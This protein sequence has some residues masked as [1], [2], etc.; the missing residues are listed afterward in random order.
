MGKENLVGR[1]SFD[2]NNSNDSS[3]NN[4]HGSAK[5]LFQPNELSNLHTWLDASDT[6]S[7]SI[8]EATTSGRVSTWHDKSGNQKDYSTG[9]GSNWNLSTDTTQPYTNARTIN[10]LNVLDF[11]GTEFLR[12]N[13]SLNLQNFSIFMVGEFDNGGTAFSFSNYSQTRAD[14]IS[15]STSNFQGKLTRLS[16]IHI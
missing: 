2:N 10:S 5:R 9:G 12:G 1:W 3:G 15:N 6:S 4:H 11:R 7:S 13:H 8:S 14:F 16:L